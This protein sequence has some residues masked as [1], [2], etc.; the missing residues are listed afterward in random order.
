MLLKSVMQ[1]SQLLTSALI[2]HSGKFSLVQNFT[3]MR[4]DSFRRNSR[5]FYFCKTNV[6]RSNHTPTV[7]GHTPHANQRNTIEWQ[8]EEASMY[9]NV[10]VFFC[11]EAF[12]I[13]KASGLP[14]WARNWL[15]EQK[16]SVVLISTSTTPEH[17]LQVCWCFVLLYSDHLKGRQTVVNHLIP[18]G[19]GKFVL[20]YAHNGVI[21]YYLI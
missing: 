21:N 16:D 13:V 10:L 8:S 11:V 17:L 6:S 4:P 20:T 5:G 15:V 7:D 19:H 2:L 9:N 18:M 12:G 14:P 1:P 3:K